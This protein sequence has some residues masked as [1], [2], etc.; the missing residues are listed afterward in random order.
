MAL[1]NQIAQRGAQRVFTQIFAPIIIEQTDTNLIEVSELDTPVW[2]RLVLGTNN[3]GGNDNYTNELGQ[4]ISIKPLIIDTILIDVQQTNNIVK[5]SVQ[6]RSGTVKEYINRG[7][8]AL[9]FRGYISNGNKNNINVYPEEQVQNFVNIM[10]KNGSIIVTN[11]RLND[12][13]K[14]DEV[15]IN[16]YNLPTVEGLT[17]L[18]PFSFTAIS[19]LPKDFQLVLEE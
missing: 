17:N 5:T 6:G 18:Q 19:E 11:Q 15:V 13:Y 14:I 12:I 16:S 10:K 4:S 2:D 7:D 1:P 9:T 3:E 8:Y